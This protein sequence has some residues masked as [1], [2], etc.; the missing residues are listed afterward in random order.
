MKAESKPI[1][2]A[3]CARK[4][5]QRMKNTRLVA[6]LLTASLISISGTTLAQDTC[7]EDTLNQ[8]CSRSQEGLDCSRAEGC[9]DGVVETWR[10][11]C[12]DGVDP[13]VVKKRIDEDCAECLRRYCTEKEP[14][15]KGS[16][17][18]CITCGPEK[19]DCDIYNDYTKKRCDVMLEG[20]KENLTAQLMVCRCR[21]TWH[22]TQE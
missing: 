4:R 18:L 7:S 21:A 11:R 9:C 14:E 19:P 10:K 16:C 12:M 6:A 17:R 22:R 8:Q 20:C 2:L 1:V 5:I 15:P 13:A 3:T